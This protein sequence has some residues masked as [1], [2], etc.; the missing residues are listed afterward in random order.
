M[1]IHDWT[2]VDAGIFH[3]FHQTWIPLIKQALNNGILPANYYALAEQTIMGPKPD[4]ITLQ[5]PLDAEGTG[6]EISSDVGLAVATA[7]PVVAY[8]TQSDEEA[9]YAKTADAV[10]IRHRSGHNVVAI[11]EIVSPGNKNSE[12][13]FEMFAKKVWEALQS[14]VHVLII[15]LFPPGPRDPGGVHPAIWEDFGGDDFQLPPDKPLT[16]ASYA[17]DTTVEGYIEPVSVGDALPEMPIFL[18]PGR[19]VNVPLEETYQRAWQA[20][21]EYWRNIVEP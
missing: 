8:H 7:P 9:I 5:R 10:M 12:R 17:A 20:V 18:M 16:L 3:D 2:R 4:V 1:P 11:I 13:G 21:P 19:Y 6:E 14:G 15:D